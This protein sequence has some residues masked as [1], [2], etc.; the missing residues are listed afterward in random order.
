MADPNIPIL[1]AGVKYV[2]GCIL[3]WQSNTTMVL[4]SGEARDNSDTNDIIITNSVETPI[5]VGITISTLF[6]GPNGLDAATILPDKNYYIYAVGDSTGNNVAAGL[7]SGDFIFPKLPVGYDI[8]RRVGC[9]R[10]DGSANILRWFQYGRAQDRTYYHDAP[11][12][13]L[14]GGSD[15]TFTEVDLIFGMPRFYA[16]GTSSITPT[17][18][19]LLSISYTPASATN[20]LEFGS[21]ASASTSLS[22]FGAGV[23]ALQKT[24]MIV[25]TFNTK[26]YYKVIAGDSVDISVAGFKDYLSTPQ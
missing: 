25:P 15:T 1:N 19:A 6:V 24:M 8:F 20:T 3:Q 7:I 21:S 11:I 14:T 16:P 22:I 4:Y 10:T 12:S 9:M 17:S 18:E 13:V 2:N 26:I 23:A 5:D